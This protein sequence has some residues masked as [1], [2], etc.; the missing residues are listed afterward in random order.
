MLRVPDIPPR[1]SCCENILKSYGHLLEPKCSPAIQQMLKD[2]GKPEDLLLKGGEWD[3]E[4]H[5]R[6]P[7]G[8]FQHSAFRPDADEAKAF[9]HSLSLWFPLDEIRELYESGETVGALA[10]AYGVGFGTMLR[11]LKDARASMRPNSW[12]QFSQFT[13]LWIR[14]YL[15]DK[16]PFDQIAALGFG[17]DSSTIH[18]YIRNAG[19]QIRRCNVVQFHGH[20]SPIAGQLKLRGAWERAYAQVLDRWYEEKLIEGWS[21]ESDKVP[22][23]HSGK[24]Y[25]PDFV[26]RQRSGTKV[27]HEVKGFCRPKSAAKIAEARASGA[28]VVLVT[29]SLLTSLCNHYKIPFSTKHRHAAQSM[30]FG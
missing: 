14:L 28:H 20:I 25:L 21:Y 15:N 18:R 6:N 23:E 27:F 29:G 4:K 24:W 13:E 12:D 16:L 7:D 17:A 22:L 8:T 1:R 3:E 2:Y 11:R 30:H 5:P 26:I 19:V 10:D 9:R